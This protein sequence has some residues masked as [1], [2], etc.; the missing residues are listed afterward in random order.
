MYCC[1]SSAINIY[2][3]T[4]IQG[5]KSSKHPTH[6]SYAK[7]PSSPAPPDPPQLRS[8]SKCNPPGFASPGTA[9]LLHAVPMFGFQLT[10]GTLGFHIL[11]VLG[12][13]AHCFHQGYKPAAPLAK[14]WPGEIA[15]WK[16]Q[17]EFSLYLNRILCCISKRQK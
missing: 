5:K 6:G 4:C 8:F 9:C 2:C 16:P 15:L 3:G 11:A 10:W 7:L 12:N 13:G 1:T 14:C 17:F